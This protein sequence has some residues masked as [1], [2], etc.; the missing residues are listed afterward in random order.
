MRKAL[1]AIGWLVGIGVLSVAAWFGINATDE[2]L[3]AD[4]QAALLLPPPPPPDRQNGFIDFLALGAPADAP[5]YE[6]GI[7][8]IAIL[9]GKADGATLSLPRSGIPRCKRGDYLACVAGM[10]DL[11]HNID[12]QAVFLARYREMRKKP[13]FIDLVVPQSPE[14][15]LP[16]FM[17]F[18]EGNRL[19]LM[20]AALD[21]NAG[22]HSAA[23]AEIEAELGFYRKVA[24]DADTLL[25]KMLAFAMLDA[26]AIFAAE[27]ARKLP[28]GE[29]ALWTRLQ[30]AVRPPTASELDVVPAMRRDR[31]QWAEWMRTRRYVRMPDV[32]YQVLADYYG[33]PGG[34]PWWDPVAP[35]LYRPHQ[36]VNKFVAQSVA[37]EALAKAPAREFEAALVAHRARVG[38]LEPSPWSSWVLNPVGNRH[39][40][41]TQSDFADYVARAHTLTGVHA[42]VALQIRL[43]AA[44]ITRPADVE[45]ALAGPLGREYPDPFTAEPMV[46]D[47]AAMTLGFATEQKYATGV[48]RDALMKGLWVALPL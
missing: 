27:V 2:A 32:M 31:A 12:E 30:A 42:L 23:I 22:R 47:P 46:F 21:F 29:R 10:S 39:H 14:A 48:V 38:A 37:S 40:Y 6:T 5:T 4:A 18:T 1:K 8:Q 7:A 15:P 34:R 44:G 41:L 45:K 17:G 3:S 25:P 24:S 28:R 19:L 33:K 16:A 43:R 26:T 9:N 20:R 11:R 36:S 13:R 35:Y